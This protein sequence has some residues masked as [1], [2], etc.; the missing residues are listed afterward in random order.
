MAF[1]EQS[2]VRHT[3]MPAWGIGRV[4]KIDEELIWIEFSGAGMKKLKAEIAAEHLV[5]ADLEPS[6]PKPAQPAARPAAN[7]GSR[8]PSRS[9]ARCA[10]CDQLLKRSQARN[11]GA[12]KSCPNCSAFE[13]EHVFYPYP[14]AFGAAAT[15]K[16]AARDHSDCT[17]CRANEPLPHEGGT[18]CSQI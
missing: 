8:A 17:Q 13:G 6:T 18:H 1:K 15:T 14:D 12:L 2:L 9:D 11:D 7:P 3:K 16:E 10:H 4:L 5:A